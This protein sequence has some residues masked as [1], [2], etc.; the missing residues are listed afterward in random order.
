MRPET[1]GNI[2]CSRLFFSSYQC[3]LTRTRIVSCTSHSPLNNW[4][5]STVL[6]LWK[7]I[8]PTDTKD[9]SFVFIL[10]FLYFLFSKDILYCCLAHT[11]FFFNAQDN[12]LSCHI[13]IHTWQIFL[14]NTM[15]AETIDTQ[16]LKYK[17]LFRLLTYDSY[18]KNSLG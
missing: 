3:L 9:F 15:L 7:K 16:H 1:R 18:G 8:N 14:A 12:A 4:I 17:P 11:F 6:L 10:L 13:I 5:I 2:C